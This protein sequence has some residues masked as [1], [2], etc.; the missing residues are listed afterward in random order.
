MN[1]VF[2]TILYLEENHQYFTEE[3]KLIILEDWRENVYNKYL[4]EKVEIFSNSVV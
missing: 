2:E 1:D 3:E 4:L